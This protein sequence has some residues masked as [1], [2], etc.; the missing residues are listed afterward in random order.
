V[1]DCG[2][3]STELHSVSLNLAYHAYWMLL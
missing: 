1:Y 2:N 3:I